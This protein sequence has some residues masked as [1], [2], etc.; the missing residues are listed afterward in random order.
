MTID[1]RTIHCMHVILSGDFAS[2]LSE[3]DEEE[4]QAPVAP[5]VVKAVPRQISQVC[6]R[7]IPSSYEIS[8]S[9][10]ARVPTVAGNVKQASR[11]GWFTL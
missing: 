2:A 9:N 6:L 10:V 7:N 1:R 3:S 11:H 5:A 4:E 8:T